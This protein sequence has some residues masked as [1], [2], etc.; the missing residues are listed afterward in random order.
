MR[1]DQE[2]GI[3]PATS[4]CKD[5]AQPTEPHSQGE[6]ICFEKI[7]LA[8][9]QMIDYRR[10]QHPCKWNSRSFEDI[11]QGA[12]VAMGKERSRSVQDTLWETKLVR[13]DEL[14]KAKERV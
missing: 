7:A 4:W 3:K 6:L 9:V 11:R 14:D 1:P 5:D 13:L 10:A 12:A 2:S 8:A